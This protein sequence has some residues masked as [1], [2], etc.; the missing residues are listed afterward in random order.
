MSS[1]KNLTSAALLVAA[2]TLT[3]SLS[4]GAEVVDRGNLRV[5]FTGK[6]SPRTLPRSGAAPISVTVAAKIAATAGAKPPQLRRMTI[7]INANGRLDP[8]ALPRC[9]VEQIQPATTEGALEACRGS[10]V[11]RGS[12][13]ARVLL[14]EQTPFPS[15]GEVY[16]FNGTYKGRPAILAHV[17]GTEPAPTSYT[18]P[19]QITR[20]KGGF[21]TL[22]TAS[23]PQVTSEWG[24]VTG[25]S[26]AL[27]GRGK[28]GPYLSAGC[29]AP[30]GF[31]GAVFPFAR[32]VFAFADGKALSATLTRSCKVRG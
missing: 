32:S 29:P 13:S 22:L 31:P 6:L 16:A 4:A 20:G 27:A 9:T 24:Y 18:L 23:L 1:S 11:G 10:L 21:G 3:L 12:F 30:E 28:K 2:M 17:Y 7:A 19:F 5:S 25:L 15:A 14:P 8:G 26:L